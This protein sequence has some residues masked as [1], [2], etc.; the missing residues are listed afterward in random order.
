MENIPTIRLESRDFTVI[1][2]SRLR[3]GKVLHNDTNNL[4]ARLGEKEITL[5]EQ[6]HTTALRKKGFPVPE[7]IYSGNY[8]DEWYFIEK[9]L[10]KVPFHKLFVEE[11]QASGSVSNTSFKK[12]LD[13]IKR[14]SLAQMHPKNT[15]DV[16]AEAFVTALIPRERVIPSYAYFKHDVKKYEQAIEQ[17]TARLSDAHMGILQFDLNP[18]NILENGII[19]FEL[20]GYGP[21]GYDSLMSAI[22]AGTWFT[23]YPSRYPIGYR[24]TDQQVE[25]NRQRID[26]LA[27]TH[28]Y[29]KPSNYLNEFLL[30][31]CAWAASGFYP[32]QPDWPNDKIAFKRFR[33]N[34]LKSAIDEY[35]AGNDIPYQLFPTISGGEIDV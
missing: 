8:G 2:P 33:T 7:V 28:G 30:L 32:P 15:T 6:I 26:R 25:Q 27:E 21:V 3:E 31:K 35:L 16:S 24:L 4:Y 34:V 17:A 19:D 12:Y 1:K 5:E 22:W 29:P 20:V 23:N 13:V 14:Y 18:Y 9:S 11:Y 10:G